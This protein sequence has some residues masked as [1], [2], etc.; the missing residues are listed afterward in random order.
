MKRLYPT[1]LRARLTLVLG[2]GSVL[3]VSVLI[4]SF[5]LVLRNQIHSDLDA[6][7]KERASAALANVV[8]R[9]G[10][11]AVREAPG[12]QAIDQQVWVF[13][14]GRLV[15]APVEPPGLTARARAAAAHPGHFSDLASLDVRLYSH[16]IKSHDRKV[17]AVVAGASLAPY[18]T[19]AQ[20][21]LAAS[22]VLGLL[23]AAG[24]LA[25]GR[26]AIAAALRPVDRMTAEAAAWS[27]DDLDH[28]FADAGTGYELAR[29]GSTFNDLLAR[30]AAGFR[31]E[32]RF[33]AELS[34]EL[35]TPL[36]KL[37]V[38]CELAL[39][40]DRSASQYRDA[41][42][43]I[44]ADARQMQGV[45][46]TLLAVARSEIDPRS[47]TADASAVARSVVASLKTRDRPDVELE[48]LADD[49]PVRVGVDAEL[50]ERVLAPVVANAL[51]FA[52]QRAAVEVQSL[53]STVR[54]LVRDDGPGVAPGDREA[55]FLPGYRSSSHGV[56]NGTGGTGL[57]LALARRLAQAADG[58]VEC[59]ESVAGGAFVVSLPAA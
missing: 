13:A 43:S 40:R 42:G 54:F 48:V 33:S 47:G 15:E 32:Q 36:A 23:I 24:T 18:E 37:I 57:G 12:D 39:R 31:H 50:A 20:R 58:D 46:E 2:L 19:T 22:I 30:L 35:K 5:N 25:A 10:R 9:R 14:G 44:V 11:V 51:Q 29:L 26:L 41:L 59:V 8:V 3:L 28:R 16:P 49:P 56:A 38:E 53:Q 55:I 7:L 4:A 17:G 21:A 27:V 6:R 52:E 45:I 1:T 34:H